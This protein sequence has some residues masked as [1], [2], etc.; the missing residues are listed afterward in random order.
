MLNL[1]ASLTELTPNWLSQTLGVEVTAFISR[2]NAAF[3]SSIAHL[4]LTYAQ[5]ADLPRHILLKLNTEHDGRNEIQFY[6]LAKDMQLPIPP[7]LAFEY[8]AD[9]GRSYI[10]MEDFSESH[11]APVTVAQLKAGQGVPSAETLDAIID[12]LADFH[13]AFWE[14][15][16]FG[17]IPDITE[18]RWWYR[19]ADFHTKHIER[20]R[21]DWEKFIAAFG[22]EIP[23]AWRRIG[24]SALGALPRLFETRIKPRLGG[25]SLT[26]SQG[27]CYLTQFLIPRAGA[28][29]TFLVDFQDASVNFP[30]YDLVYLLATFWTREQRAGYEEHL[31]RRYLARLQRDYTWDELRDDYRLCLKYMFFDAVWNAAAG[32][33]RE[34]WWTKLSCLVSAYEDW[35]CEAL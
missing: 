14:H 8:D 22:G 15:P 21:G 2:D 4:D 18:M 5:P 10:L 24:E 9:S 30:A 17:T 20:R 7:R 19:N 25:R 3:N 23:S 12:T 27:D 28:R 11:I 34:Y 1:L 29:R 35:D 31:L 16:S 26:L 6:R 32:S 33:S 13:A